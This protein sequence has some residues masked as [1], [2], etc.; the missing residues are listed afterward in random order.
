MIV[1]CVLSYE[2]EVTHIYFLRKIMKYLFILILSI[3]IYEL[4]YVKMRNK[5]LCQIISEKFFNHKKTLYKEFS[6]TVNDDV[7]VIEMNGII[8]ANWKYSNHRV[9]SIE[10]FDNDLFSAFKEIVL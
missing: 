3:I 10:I 2:C 4:F 7:F 9:S 5:Y 6:V 8:V 1:K